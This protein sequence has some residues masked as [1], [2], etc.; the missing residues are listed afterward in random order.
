[1]SLIIENLERMLA[2][3]ADNAML[4]YGLGKAY[5]DAKELEAAIDH[6]KRAVEQDPD[7]SA[8]WKLLG[9][10]Y[11]GAERKPEAIE[12]YENGIR[13]AEGRGDLQAAKEMRVFLRR[14]KP[15]AA[16]SD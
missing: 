11:A 16:E 4:R 10:A 3:G 8:A 13:V 12:A 7:Y 9:R 6:L 14:L 1:M 2:G 5:L 15:T